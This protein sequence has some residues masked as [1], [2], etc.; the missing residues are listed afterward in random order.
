LILAYRSKTIF[1]SRIIYCQIENEKTITA[2]SIDQG[3]PID[4]R[5]IQANAI[6]HDK[7][8]LAYRSKTI[9]SSRIIDCQIEN[10]E[11][12]TAFR[13]DE[14]VPIDSRIIQANAIKH[15]KLILAYRPK[16]IFSSGVIDCE[17]Q[18]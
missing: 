16:T 4:S 5:R 2:F 13:I 10:E 12:I 14:G 6:K 3:V 15:D 18:V 1:T 11:T 8:I 17:D 9:F 7:L